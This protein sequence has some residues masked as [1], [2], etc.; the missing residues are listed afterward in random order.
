MNKKTNMADSSFAER[1]A[2]LDEACAFLRSFTLGRTGF[3][4][5]DGAAGIE[6]VSAECDRMR[7]LFST[8]PYA[9]QV[10]TVIASARSRIIAAQTRL[11][12]LL[13]KKS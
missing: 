3:T 13:K 8:G 5:K 6:R 1:K 10:V 12:H 7:E 11:N 4:R 2:A 9:K